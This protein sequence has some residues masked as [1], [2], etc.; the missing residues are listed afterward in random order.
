MRASRFRH[1]TFRRW[2]SA[3]SEGAAIPVTQTKFVVWRYIQMDWR[4]SAYNLTRMIVAV[5]LSLL[6]GLIFVRTDYAS[7]SGLNSGVGMIFIAALFNSMVA[8]QSVLP[9]SCSERGSFYREHAS[10]TYNAFWYFVGSTLAEIPFCFMLI[11]TEIFYPFMG[12]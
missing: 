8:F 11:F 3:R 2:S 9:L 4:T 1:R 7:N 10:Q 5:F 12:F 6:F